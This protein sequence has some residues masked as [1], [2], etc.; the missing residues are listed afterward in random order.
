MGYNR[1]SKIY[2]LAQIS[3]A[4]CCDVVVVKMAP[5]KSEIADVVHIIFPLNSTGLGKVIA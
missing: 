1:L 4:F 2:R 3:P 5:W